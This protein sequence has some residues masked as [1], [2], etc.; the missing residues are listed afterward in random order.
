MIGDAV[1]MRQVTALTWHDGRYVTA[2]AEAA[3]E[4]TSHALPHQSA[5]GGTHS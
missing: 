2:V 3:G 1:T 5:E 4:E